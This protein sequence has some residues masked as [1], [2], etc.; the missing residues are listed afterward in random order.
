MFSN[1]YQ[2]ILFFYFLNIKLSFK[3]VCIKSF[4]MNSYQYFLVFTAMY[5][6]LQE[7]TTEMTTEAAEHILLP[8]DC[9]VCTLHT[10]HSMINHYP[11]VSNLVLVIHCF[12]SND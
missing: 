2:Y 8:Y 3:K 1:V 7:K 5:Y 4:F 10:V 6:H 9:T 11:L 12:F